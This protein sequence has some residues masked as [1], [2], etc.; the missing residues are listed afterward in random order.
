MQLLVQKKKKRSAKEEC[1]KHIQLLIR[2]NFFLKVLPRTGR[3]FGPHV[4][5]TRNLCLESMM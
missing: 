4:T 3:R 1:A 2:Y 5:L